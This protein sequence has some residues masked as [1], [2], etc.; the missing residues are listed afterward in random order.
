MPGARAEPHRVHAIAALPDQFPAAE[1][2]GVEGRDDGPILF[3]DLDTVPFREL[4]EEPV[5]HA[6]D[7]AELVAENVVDAVGNSRRVHRVDDE[8]VAQ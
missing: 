5:V 6:V 7:D 4:V 2:S 3:G 1:D 8:P